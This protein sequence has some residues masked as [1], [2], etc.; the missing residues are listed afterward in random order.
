MR[1]CTKQHLRRVQLANLDN[2][3]LLVFSG[4]QTRSQSWTTEAES[5]YRLALSLNQPLPTFRSEDEITSS[6]AP[7]EPLETGRAS[8]KLAGS[9]ITLAAGSHDSDTLPD[10]TKFR[11][12]TEDYALD[13]YENLLYSIARFYEFTGDY[14]QKITV[15]GY[16][17]KKDRFLNLHTHALRWPTSKLL[18]DGS[19]AFSY[20]G[21]DDDGTNLNLNKDQAYDLFERDMYGCYSK[22]L[23]R[24]S[25]LLY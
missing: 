9:S 12:T 24:T 18:P 16:N 6:H 22:L 14:P 7:F 4:G 5:Y 2:S 19:R 17:F 3:S 21:I 23:V 20:V 1:L 11:M 10:L 25:P 15:V 8:G 13:S